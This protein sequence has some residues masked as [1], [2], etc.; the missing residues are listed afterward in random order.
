VDTPVGDAVR[1][2]ADQ[3]GDR[4]LVIAEISRKRCK[5]AAQRVR[6]DIGWQ[7]TQ[8]GD[9]RPH[10]PVDDRFTGSTGEHHITD[11]WLEL[12]H[13]AGCIRR[14]GHDRPLLSWSRG[15]GSELG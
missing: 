4:R 2:V 15:R 13:A 10:L 8:L 11:R 5:A 14:C 9:L 1:L 3:A 7:I 12:D 6:R